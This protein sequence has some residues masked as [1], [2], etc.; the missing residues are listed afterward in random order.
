[1]VIRAAGES[2]RVS[3]S[4]EVKFLQSTMFRYVIESST[5]GEMTK[6]LEAFFAFLKQVRHSTCM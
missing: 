4:F 1:M 2:V 3:L 5:N 6:W